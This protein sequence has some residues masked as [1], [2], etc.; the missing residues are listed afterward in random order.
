MLRNGVPIHYHSLE[1]ELSKFSNIAF[2]GDTRHPKE[3]FEFGFQR[4]GAGWDLYLANNKTIQEPMLRQ[5]HDETGMCDVE[6]TSAVCLTLDFDC[7]SMFPLEENNGEAAPPFTWI[8]I[9][10]V[11]NAYMTYEKQI[12]ANSNLQF[13]REIATRDIPSGH[14]L[15]AIRCERYFNLN[16][17][18]EPKWYAGLHFKLVGEILWNPKLK[19]EPKTPAKILLKENIEKLIHAHQHQYLETPIPKSQEEIINFNRILS[20]PIPIALN[21]HEERRC[22]IHFAMVCA[23]PLS[24]YL[25]KA[26][27]VQQALEAIASCK[28]VNELIP[29]TRF[30]PLMMACKY[31]LPDVVKKLLAKGANPKIKNSDGIPLVEM[32]YK[33]EIKA[34]LEDAVQKL[35]ESK[36]IFNGHGFFDIAG[37]AKQL[38]NTFLIDFSDLVS[39]LDP[40]QRKNN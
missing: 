22:L 16:E 4:Y 5:T 21:K 35:D 40:L 39:T 31:N 19:N 20:T 33:P 2:R 15:C 13:C 24:F 18:F 9:V 29:G 12:K 1:N 37:T 7:A 10:Q 3:I 34:L 25:T 11:E 30:F 32:D 6:A 26:E 8:Y 14:V 36:L 28:N 17:E 38:L 23:K 27:K